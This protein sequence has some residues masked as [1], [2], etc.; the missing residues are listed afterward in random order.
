MWERG[1]VPED[2][3]AILRNDPLI[4]W[5]DGEHS[6]DRPS[7]ESGGSPRLRMTGRSLQSRLLTA[8]LEEPNEDGVAIA[9]TVFD[10]DPA[11]QRRY[12]RYRRR[13][14]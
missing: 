9:V 5:Q 11:E 14:G 4:E 6:P 13:R 8:I 12:R 10:A 7:P 2:L 1:I 3:T